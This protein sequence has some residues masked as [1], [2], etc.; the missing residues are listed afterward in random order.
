MRRPTWSG[1]SVSQPSRAAR[2][3]SGSTSRPSVCGLDAFDLA[4][5]VRGR[6]PRIAQITSNR[7]RIKKFLSRSV[8]SWNSTNLVK[9][10]QPA[11]DWSSWARART[12]I[13]SVDP[14]LSGS[15]ARRGAER[16]DIVTVQLRSTASTRPSALRQPRAAAGRVA[17]TSCWR[18]AGSATCASAASQVEPRHRRESAAVELVGSWTNGAPGRAAARGADAGG[19][20]LARRVEGTMT[21]RLGRRR[22]W[23]EARRDRR[24]CR[25][26]AAC[27]ARRRGEASRAASGRV[28]RARDFELRS[29]ASIGPSW[30]SSLPSVPALLGLPARRRAATLPEWLRRA[31]RRERH[32][33]TP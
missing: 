3:S 16:V 31:A 28:T 14:A 24:A 20:R 7:I 6:Y 19:R 32:A 12:A 22:R 17:R 29:Q 27:A 2:S 11:E 5:G 1:S 21:F 25:G 13:R 10:A 23:L 30:R 26:A 8:L 18:G 4:H 15:L 33:T 9:Y